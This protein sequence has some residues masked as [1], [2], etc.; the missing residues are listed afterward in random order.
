MVTIVA[1]M[2]DGDEKVDETHEDE[3]QLAEISETSVEDPRDDSDTDS[4]E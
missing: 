1:Q 3:E 2:G 4:G